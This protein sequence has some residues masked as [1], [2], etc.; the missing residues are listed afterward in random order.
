MGATQ[1]FM[2]LQNSDVQRTFEEGAPVRINRTITKTSMELS[3]MHSLK[4]QTNSTQPPVRGDINL[5]PPPFD[6]SL[7]R[8]PDPMCSSVP[9][10]DDH[11]RVL[12]SLFCAYF[13]H[14]RD[15]KS[16]A[17]FQRYFQAHI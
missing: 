4:R 8:D 16:T 17:T 5:R 3:T 11:L 15:M 6:S 10:L 9:P 12:G 14:G 13:S 1:P 7:M 2:T